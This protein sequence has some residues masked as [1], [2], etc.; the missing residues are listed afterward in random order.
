MSPSPM[1][2]LRALPPQNLVPGSARLV[3]G[4]YGLQAVYTLGDGDILLLERRL[5]AVAGEY[6]SA[7]G[8]YT[9]IVAE[10][11]T[12][13]NAQKALQHLQ[14]NLDRYLKIVARTPNG[15]VFEDYSKKY[16]AVAVRGAR[17]EAKVKLSKRPET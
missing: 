1:A 14:Q 11:P 5:S 15:F 17:L 4:A 9:L 6:R 12:P 3:R 13:G 8:N 10:Y 2:E 16:G 7:A